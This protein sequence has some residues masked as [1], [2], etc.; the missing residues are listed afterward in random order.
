R[1]SK[2][3][4][5]VLVT[6]TSRKKD[7]AGSWILRWLEKPLPLSWER[8]AIEASFVCRVLRSVPITVPTVAIEAIRQAM[9][10]KRSER[11]KRRGVLGSEGYLRCRQGSCKVIC[12]SHVE[13]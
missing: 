4:C 2:T 7:R 3:N 5:H 1:R 9:Q 6:S 12:C 8:A 13:L 10:R 11:H